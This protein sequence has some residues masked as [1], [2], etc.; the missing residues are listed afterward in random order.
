MN[1]AQKLYPLFLNLSA[2]EAL[3]VG[4]GSVALRK[5]NTLLEA[6]ARVRVVAPEALDEVKDLANK[7]LIQWEQRAFEDDC[8]ADALLV[9]CATD[10]TETNEQVYQAAQKAH[11]IV[12]VVDVPELCNAIVPSSFARGNLQVAVTT[13]GAAPSLARNIRKE[14][15]DQFPAHWEDYTHALGSVRKLV[16]KRVPGPSSVRTSLYE[17]LTGAGL[18][19]R[20]A[21]GERPTPEQLYQ[22]LIEPL[23]HKGG[24]R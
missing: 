18:E 6:G 20:F 7:G 4:A 8:I 14:L 2:A 22:E 5:I 11:R 19:S 23:I 15:E 9:F 1:S 10:S 16:K 3:V 17:A 24:S 21:R 13:G 12:N